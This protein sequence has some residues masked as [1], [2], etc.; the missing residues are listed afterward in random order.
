M[1]LRLAQGLAAL[2]VERATVR[3]QQQQRNLA[4]G[5]SER[6]DHRNIRVQMTVLSRGEKG[7][8]HQISDPSKENDQADPGSGSGRTTTATTATPPCLR[9]RVGTATRE[10]RNSAPGQAGTPGR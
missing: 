2:L 3:G 8:A 6:I 10:R 7:D 4:A 1:D 9:K 5:G